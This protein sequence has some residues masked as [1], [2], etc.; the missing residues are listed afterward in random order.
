MQEVSLDTLQ[1]KREL[2]KLKR[3]MLEDQKALYS[4]LMKRTGRSLTE[5]RAACRKNSD[6]TA[7][8]ALMFGLIDRIE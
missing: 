3:L 4:L 5:V 8:E 2:D 7:Q 6:M 1:N